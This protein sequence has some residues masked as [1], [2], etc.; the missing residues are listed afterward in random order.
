LAGFGRKQ[1]VTMLPIKVTAAASTLFTIADA[2]AHLRVDQNN[3]DGP[4]GDMLAAAIDEAARYTSRAINQQ[5]YRQ[6]W[7]RWPDQPCEL[8]ELQVAPVKSVTSIK[9]L[10]A[11]GD[12]QTL[13]GSNYTWHRTDRGATIDFIASITFPTL[14]ETEKPA[15][16]VDFVAGY[17]VGA[18]D[19][20][21]LPPP[22]IKQA[23]MMT[24][25]HF[26]ANREAVTTGKVPMVMPRG[27]EHLLDF[28]RIYR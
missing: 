12:E 28:L 19:A 18:S 5:T 3:E 14:H 7:Y 15:V 11:S 9:Y 20:E 4:I 22:A 13:A 26:Y 10:D 6:Q 25:G 27:A 24:V 21:L 1:G 17:E 8:L 16:F 23:V 2:K